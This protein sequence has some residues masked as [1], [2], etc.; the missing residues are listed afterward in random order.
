MM[1]EYF[2]AMGVLFFCYL[3]L[4]CAF[5]SVWRLPPAPP[6]P[7]HLEGHAIETGQLASRVQQVREEIEIAEPGSPARSASFKRAFLVENKREEMAKLD[8][9]Q[10]SAGRI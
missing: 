2:I 3:C 9:F 10:D 5:S 6:E 8:F 1:A 7:V 4:R